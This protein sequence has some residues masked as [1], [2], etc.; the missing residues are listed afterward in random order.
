MDADQTSTAT[1]SAKPQRKPELIGERDLATYFHTECSVCGRPLQ[2]LV[3][4]F[5]QAVACGH[6]GGRFV[7]TDPAA[8]VHGP[9]S[10]LEQAN[11]LLVLCSNLRSARRHRLTPCSETGQA[12]YR[13]WGIEM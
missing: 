6:C 1:R 13:R 2:V 7:A 5:G 11:Q 9:C 4:Y 10:V 12:W 8:N 3:E